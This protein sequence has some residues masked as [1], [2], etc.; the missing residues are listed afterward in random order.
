MKKT[1]NFE[2]G[3]EQK[4][5]NLVDLENPEKMKWL[6]QK[7]GAKALKNGKNRKSILIIL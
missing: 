1:A 3:A 6:K 2:F 5:E 7:N 4:C